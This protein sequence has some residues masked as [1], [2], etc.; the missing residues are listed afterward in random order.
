M[1]DTKKTATSLPFGG[2]Q[3]ASSTSAKIIQK[4]LLHENDVEILRFQKAIRQL[5]SYVTAH[6]TGICGYPTDAHSTIVFILT[7][8]EP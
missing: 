6:I 2:V 1:H 3:L 8:C 7:G 5:V 4:T